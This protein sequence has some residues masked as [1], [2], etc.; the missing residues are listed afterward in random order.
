MFFAPVLVVVCSLSSARAAEYESPEGF[1]LTLPEK[2][3]IASKEELDKAVELTKKA[4]GKDPG[5][6]AYFFGPPSENFAPNINVIILNVPF[7]L[8]DSFEKGM[9]DGM[10]GAF[11]AQ[12]ATAPE[13]K[14]SHFQVDGHKLFSV[15]FEKDD[16][17]SQKPMRIWTVA[18]AT[19]NGGCV[20]TC[21]ALKSQWADAGPAIKSIINSLKFDGV[22]AN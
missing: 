6:V 1:K 21:G 2:W 19:K 5:I 15:A 12:G 20:M 14:T 11:T 13:F 10:K 7:V 22:P 9:I 16:P 17:T 18:F 4:A 3:R 8:N